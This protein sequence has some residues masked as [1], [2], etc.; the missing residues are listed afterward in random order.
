MMKQ[1]LPHIV[2]PVA[3]VLEH[4]PLLHTW[5]AVQTVVQLPQWAGSDWVAV[6]VDGEPQAMKPLAHLH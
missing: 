4:C 3:Q 5:P 1:L 2:W 6:Q